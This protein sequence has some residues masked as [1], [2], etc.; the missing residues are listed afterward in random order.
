MKIHPQI[1]SQNKTPV[2]VV[3]PYNE[4]QAIVEILE[5]HADIK[6][7]KANLADNSERFP[8]ALI[9]H[10]AAGENP[11]K[12]YREYRQLSQIQLAEQVGVSRQ[13]ISQLENGE[14][15]GSTKILHKIAKVLSISIIDLISSD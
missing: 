4:Y 13:Y 5:N 8:L 6:S 14:R 2:F 9:E 1:I 10:I 12:A 3:L 15:A 7:V 11:I